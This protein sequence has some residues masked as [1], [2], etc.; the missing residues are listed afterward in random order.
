MS[1]DK[2]PKARRMIS[3][4]ERAYSLG[5]YVITLLLL[6]AFGWLAG[7]VVFAYPEALGLFY[8]GSFS[9]LF[10]QTVVLLV[11]GIPSA[12]VI[13]LV[14]LSGPL[15]IFMARPISP[16]RAVL[17]GF[18]TSTTLI[19]VL[20]N[21]TVWLGYT[22]P[23]SSYIL[24][25]GLMEEPGLGAIFVLLCTLSAGAMQRI[26]GPGKWRAPHQ[27]SNPEKG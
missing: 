24:W 15:W 4:P 18:V 1:E 10:A 26:I 14:F 20:A 16:I 17:A 21:E 12:G 27:K 25:K 9:D 23:P 11:T 22:W 3:A 7:F 2:Q 19:L 13:A 5:Q 8:T 6:M